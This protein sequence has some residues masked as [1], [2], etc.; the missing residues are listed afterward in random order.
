MSLYTQ[1]E[2]ATAIGRDRNPQ[3]FPKISSIFSICRKKW[4]KTQFNVVLNKFGFRGANPPMI[5]LFEKKSIPT[6]PK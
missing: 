6:S 2:Y 3:F 4:L 5:V 1:S